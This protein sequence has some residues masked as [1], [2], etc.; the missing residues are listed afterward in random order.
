VDKKASD[1]RIIAAG[2]ARAN[3]DAAAAQAEPL[4]AN[5]KEEIDQSTRDYEAALKALRDKIAERKNGK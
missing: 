5:L 2:R 1:E 3:L 4:M